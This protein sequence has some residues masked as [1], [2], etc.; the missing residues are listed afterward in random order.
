M[1]DY[2]SSLPVRTEND[3]DVVAKIG[4]GAT[5]ADQWAI[6]S[7][8][9]GEVNVKDTDGD[10]L[11]VNPDGSINVNQVSTTVGTDVHEYAT[12]AAVAV[13]TPTDVVDYTVTTAKTLLLKSVQATGS[14]KCK[15][16]V[17]AGT[18]ASEA[19][20]AV[21]FVSTANGF[22]ELTFPQPIEV[23]GD[24]KVLVTVTNI[25]NAQ[26]QDLYAYIN[27]VEI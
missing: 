17:K 2:D 9:R 27:G 12:S 13:D 1:A 20:V 8:G 19:T 11:A 14:G 6:G 18:P 25:E 15:V 21:F 24:D 26:A 22:G 5:P 16:E 4:D 23:V 3:G 10:E 7:D